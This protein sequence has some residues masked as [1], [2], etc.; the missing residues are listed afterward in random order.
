MIGTGEED[1]PLAPCVLKWIRRCNPDSCNDIRV[2]Q[3]PQKCAQ[4]GVCVC[5]LP[6]H[7]RTMVFIYTTC[8]ACLPSTRRHYALTIRL[9]CGSCAH[10]RD[11]AV[12]GFGTNP[13]RMPSSPMQPVLVA[14]QI[15]A[16]G[17]TSGVHVIV[18]DNNRLRRLP[19]STNHSSCEAG[20]M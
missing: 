11:I 16:S 4:L 10:L 17:V 20:A 18:A 14:L 15:C 8:H 7:D 3:S 13:R 1:G 5:G 9:C 19:H 12:H 6:A 2:D